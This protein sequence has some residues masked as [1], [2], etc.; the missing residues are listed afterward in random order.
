MKK[1]NKHTFSLT[2]CKKEI[3][4]FEN[5]LKKPKLDENAEILPFFKKNINLCSLIRFIVS[6]NTPNQLNIAHEY[7]FWGDFA[8]D[9]AVA[10]AENK[11]ICFVEFEN[12]MPDSIFK[13]VGQKATKEYAPR[14]E[15]GYSQIIDWFYRIDNFTN[16]HEIKKKF[17]RDNIDFI[18]ILITGHSRDLDDELR[19]RLKWRENNVVISNSKILYFTFD[20]LLGS[21]KHKIDNILSI[22]QT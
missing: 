10:D 20:E 17:G 5:L 22:S 1:F 6:P 21:F 13:Q 14:F 11:T 4:E 8:C 3:I 2:N 18:G 16:S 7:D 19:K 15:H 9:L 12:C